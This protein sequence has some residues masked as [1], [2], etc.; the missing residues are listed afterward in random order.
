[1]LRRKPVT[2]AC[3]SCERPIRDEQKVCACGTATRYM[4][5]SER[6][7]YEVQQWRRYRERAA[8]TG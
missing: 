4:T 3:N 6:T 5:F 1:M 7:Q 8:A 2:D